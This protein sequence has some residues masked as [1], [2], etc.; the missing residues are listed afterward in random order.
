[1]IILAGMIGMGKT[2]YTYRL[3]EELGTQ[4]FFEPVEENSI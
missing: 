3:A 2:T 4:P 1:M